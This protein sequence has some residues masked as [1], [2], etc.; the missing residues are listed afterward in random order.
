MTEHAIAHGRGAASGPRPGDLVEPPTRRRIVVVV[1]TLLV[2]ATLL[3]LSLTT[4]PDRALFYLLTGLLAAVWV[5]GAFGSGAL[6]LGTVYRTVRPGRTVHSGETVD[7]GNVV[8]AG[9]D[10]RS[11]KGERLNRPG[12]PVLAPVV[13]GLLVGSVFV[14]GGLIVREIAPLRAYVQTVLVHVGGTAVLPVVVLIALVNAAAEE[15][16]FRGALF[17]TV[18]SRAPVLITTVIYG[19][20][21]ASTGNPMLV[22]AALLL[23]WVL[24]LQ[25]RTTGGVL[26]PVITH[27]TWSLVML[28]LLPLAVG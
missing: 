12:R 18:G 20:A 19:L 17:A 25:R 1:I 4:P 6:H 28:L 3:G 24:A 2:G 10:V 16:F 22:F 8:R 23:G 7:S 27:A 11:G 15:L 14:A 26:A 9:S 13:L 21:T 5:A